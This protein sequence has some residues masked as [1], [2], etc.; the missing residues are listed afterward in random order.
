MTHVFKEMLSPADLETRRLSTPLAL[1]IHFIDRCHGNVQCVSSRYGDWLRAGR[2]RGQSS[3]PGRGNIFLISSSRPVLVAT[4][5]PIQYVQAR[6][7]GREADHSL[8]TSAEVKRTWIYTST[9]PYIFMASCLLRQSCPCALC[10]EDVWGVDV[11]IH[12]P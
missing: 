10:H 9:P 3:S 5:P 4:Q 1:Y 2:P 7:P 6:W 11:Q 12:Y 8:P